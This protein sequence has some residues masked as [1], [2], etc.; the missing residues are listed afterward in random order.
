MIKALG[1][2]S[3]V[4]IFIPTR[5]SHLTEMSTPIPSDFHALGS[6]VGGHP[7]VMTNDSGSVIIKP[8]LPA[9][10]EFYETIQTNPVF[11]PLRVYIPKF[12]GTLK[13]QGQV[14]PEKSKDGAIVV[15][16]AS[17]EDVGDGEKDESIAFRL[18]SLCCTYWDARLH[19]P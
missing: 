1:F 12:L 7:G 8:A 3:S 15:K 9:E 13:L 4:Q 10:V 18:T 2:A 6:Q 19:I 11:E 14:D 16:E 17:R 5:S